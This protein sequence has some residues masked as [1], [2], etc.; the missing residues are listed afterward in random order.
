MFD[1]GRFLVLTEFVILKPMSSI[2]VNGENFEIASEENRLAVEFLHKVWIRAGRPN[3]LEGES[4]WKVVD[5]MMKMWSALYPH[6]IETWVDELKEEQ[7]AERNVHD[8]VKSGG[9][10]FPISY[11]T[12][13]YNML[14]VYFPNEKY[15]DHELIKKIVNRYPIFK[16]T[17]YEI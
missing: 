9:G 3:R 5:A 14:K 8:A 15:T 7:D 12:R 17:K 13:I 6:E 2:N 10:Y 16:R 1:D 11:P 4:A